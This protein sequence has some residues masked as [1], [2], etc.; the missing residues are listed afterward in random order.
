MKGIFVLFFFHNFLCLLLFDYDV[1]PKRI[2]NLR[3]DKKKI[4]KSIII[5]G[6]VC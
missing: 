5:V 4:N 1:S 2:Q 3:R 6:L